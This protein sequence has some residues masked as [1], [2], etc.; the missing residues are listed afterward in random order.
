MHP[1]RRRAVNPKTLGNLVNKARKYFAGPADIWLFLR[2][3][4]WISILPFLLRRYGLDALLRKTT[5]RN[6]DSDVD[7][8]KATV[9]VNWWLGRN[10]LMFKPTC[11]NRCLTLYKFQREC[12]R[13]MRIHYGVKQKN[14]GGLEGHSWL[15]LDGKPLSPEGDTAMEFNETFSYPPESE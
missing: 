13:P 10:F 2:V 7:S 15:S 9:F 14:E 8:E 3:A 12:G 4:V 11:L 5:P 6:A 1:G